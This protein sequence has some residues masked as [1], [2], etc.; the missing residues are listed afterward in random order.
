M[1]SIL[2]DP[3]CPLSIALV[4]EWHKTLL[5]GINDAWAGRFR[6]GKEW[7]RVGAHIGANPDFVRP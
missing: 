4:L 1:E 5:S 3:S 6:C 2:A 7:V